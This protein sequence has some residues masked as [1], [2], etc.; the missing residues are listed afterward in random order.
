MSEECGTGCGCDTQRETHYALGMRLR[1]KAPVWGLAKGA[2][3]PRCTGPVFP[4]PHPPAVRHA[5]A[6][7]AGQRLPGRPT[8]PRR[9]GGP[10]PSGRLAHVHHRP[11]GRADGRR[12]PPP[13]QP[14]APVSQCPFPGPLREPAPRAPGRGAALPGPPGPVRRQDGPGPLE[15]PL[16]PTPQRNR[17]GLRRHR[18]APR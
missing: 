2:R 1:Q 16:E 12:H 15:R 8:L 9:E 6:G 7:G 3:R 11:T 18:P 5:R 4:L 17:P 10:G 14:G 13:R